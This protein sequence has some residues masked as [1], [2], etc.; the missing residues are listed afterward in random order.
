MKLIKFINER[1]TL[2]QIRIILQDTLHIV[3][4][5]KTQQILEP[6]GK[7]CYSA[8]IYW[9]CITELLPIKKHT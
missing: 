7:L 6:F 5:A 4:L 8:R 1:A 2:E 3:N 9:A